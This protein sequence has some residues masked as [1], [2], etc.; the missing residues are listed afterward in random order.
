LIGCF[1]GIEA[2]RGIAWRA[3]DSLALHA[4]FVAYVGYL[5]GKS[6]LRVSPAWSVVTVVTATIL[7]GVVQLALPHEKIEEIAT[8]IAQS[9]SP[10]LVVIALVET[11]GIWIP[12]LAV[13]WAVLPTRI[14]ASG[15]IT[16]A[17]AQGA[18]VH[19]QPFDV[20][21]ALDGSV[22][23]NHPSY[24]A[25]LVFAFMFA[26]VP[27]AIGLSSKRRQRRIVP[28]RNGPT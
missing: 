8:A 15:Y 25:A 16:G 6:D 5:L 7:H 1:E 19:Y 12:V 4:L 28:T 18:L 27:F 17:A 23:P 9:L 20:E 2:E 21:I 11:A 10:G 14:A 24:E 26:A 3:A 22:V 13:P